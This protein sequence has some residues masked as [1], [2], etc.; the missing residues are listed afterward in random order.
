MREKSERTQRARA[1]ASSSSSHNSGENYK[2]RTVSRGGKGVRERERARGRGCEQTARK[3]LRLGFCTHETLPGQSRPTILQL[4]FSAS[5]SRTTLCSP[6]LS[7][8]LGRKALRHFVHKTNWA[9][10]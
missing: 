10:T 6:S 1:S 8:A 9:T 7:T 3:A 2:L 4:S 5:V